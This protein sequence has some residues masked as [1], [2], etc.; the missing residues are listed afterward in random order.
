MNEIDFSEYNFDTQK[1][2]TI[3][4]FGEFRVLKS[5]VDKVNNKKNGRTKTK[6]DTGQEQFNSDNC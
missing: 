6:K 2:I 1:T 4:F 5:V 3:P